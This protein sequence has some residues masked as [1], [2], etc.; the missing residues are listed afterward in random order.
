MTKSASRAKSTTSSAKTRTKEP[1]KEMRRRQLR[2]SFGVRSRELAGVAL[3]ALAILSLLALAGWTHGS[4]SD[5]WSGGLFWLFG[6]G[7][8]AFAI[9]LGA[10]GV[11]II[12]RT[13]NIVT[14]MPWRAF[15]FVEMAFF[16]LLAVLHAFAI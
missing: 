11:L 15:I 9:L 1:R 6:W 5:G 3:I 8:F 2:Y 4:L 10:I 16:A 14:A 12:A 7:A 13:Q